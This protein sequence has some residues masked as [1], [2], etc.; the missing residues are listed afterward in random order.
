MRLRLVCLGL[1]VTA[2][3]LGNVHCQAQGPRAETDTDHG[4][5]QDT[6]YRGGL[7]TPPL[8][9]PEFTLTDTKGTPFDFGARRRDT[10][11][12]CSSAIRNA[13]ACVRCKWPLWPAQ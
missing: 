9:K 2:V 10:S 7:V 12:C 5:L 3:L 11:H 13:R 4:G 6:A 8:P 1:A